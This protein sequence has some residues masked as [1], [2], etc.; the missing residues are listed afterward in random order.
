[1]KKKRRVILHSILDTRPST[2]ATPRFLVVDVGNTTTH[3]GICNSEN[4]LVRFR[5][6]SM[7]SII[8][9]EAPLA[10]KKAGTKGAP[11]SGILLSSVVPRLRPTIRALCR[12]L[13]LRPEWLDD[14]T[15][16]GVRLLYKNPKEIGSDRIAN[17]AAAKEMFGCPAIVVDIGTA[18][19]FDCVSSRG[20][21]LGGIIAPGP[22]LSRVALAERTGLLPFVD[23][24]N[25]P[26]LIGKSTAHAIQSGMIFGT[27]AL[28]SGLIGQLRKEIGGNPRAIFTGGQLDLI[29]SGWNYPRIIEPNLTLHGLRIIYNRV[30]SI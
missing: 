19:T 20:A 23:I 9:K 4:I 14:K 13:G 30:S 18:I 7:A 2:P 27:R 3:F 28:I 21:Y 22:K 5:L 10:I 11:L 6:P 26:R 12:R 8:L 15:P 17:V 24:K 25:P 1:M 16:T 29:I